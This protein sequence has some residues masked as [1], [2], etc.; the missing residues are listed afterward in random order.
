M[1]ASSVPIPLRLAAAALAAASLA[2][3]AMF[4]PKE[5]PPLRAEVV[6]A[7]TVSNRLIGFN[8]GRPHRITSNVAITG[9]DTG[10]TL[11]GIDFR[12][13]SGRLYGAGST[14]RLYTIDVATGV[15]TAVG[16]GSYFA[17]NVGADNGFDF[18]PA[19]DRIR[20]VN[21][22]GE[23]LRLHPD[24]GAVVDGDTNVPGLQ[25]DGRLAYAVGDKGAA[26]KS[27]R[28]VAAAYT[29]SVAGAKVTTNFAI[30]AA[31]GTLVTQGTVQGAPN[32]VSPNTGRLFTVGALGVKIESGPVS[33]DISPANE[34]F[35]SLPCGRHT[36]VYRI[37]L[38]TGAA[39]DLG[40]VGIDEQVRAVAVRP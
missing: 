20:V 38:A 24:T 3:C 40:R 34:G 5:E 30:D 7:V 32:P 4:K 33:F 17:A 8:A 15:A 6:V 10:E 19:V 9:L 21:E 16:A 11:A 36:R 2:S 12:P 13:A 28:I 31:A 14:G 25:L 23:N 35:V 22:R 27:P 18:N 29:N 39:T 26:G 37:D 1:N